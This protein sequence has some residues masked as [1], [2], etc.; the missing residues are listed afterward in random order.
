MSVADKVAHYVERVRVSDCKMA[1][2]EPGASNL[3]DLINPN[4]NRSL[5]YSHTLEQVRERYPTAEIVNFEE[6]LKAKAREQD[7]EITWVATTEDRY[8]KMLEVLP[9]AFWEGDYFLVGEPYD[10]HATSGRP[11][12]QAF[13][14]IGGKYFQA[15]RPMTVQ[16]LKDFL[17]RR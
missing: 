2:A 1:F 9:P 12:Y 10:H 5:I 11:R 7:S 4:T 3:I 15:S 16:E 6:W 8:T 13:G 17:Q 14:Y